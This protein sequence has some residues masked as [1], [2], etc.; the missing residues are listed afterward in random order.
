MCIFL[1]IYCKG[2][3]MISDLY[4]MV[5]MPIMLFDIVV[6]NT[7][8][9]AVRIDYKFTKY[10]VG[11]VYLMKS[12]CPSFQRCT[13]IAL[14]GFFSVNNYGQYYRV[15]LQSYHSW[16]YEHL[17]ALNIQIAIFTLNDLLCLAWHV[18]SSVHIS[19]WPLH[20]VLHEVLPISK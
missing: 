1:G 2:F 11:H 14:Y 13:I 15:V 17:F 20:E 4:V 3:I 8:T 9:T 12:H 18:F 6:R 7:V 16:W 19:I 5:S 10:S